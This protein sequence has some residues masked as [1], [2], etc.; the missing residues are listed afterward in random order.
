[1]DRRSFLRSLLMAGGAVATGAA[2]LPKSAEAAPFDLIKDIEAAAKPVPEAD[3]P[4]QGAQ[5]VWHRGRAH[6]RWQRPWRQPRRVCRTR[7]SR[8]GRVV[9]VCRW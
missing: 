2:L 9:R 6:G 8:W 5:E 3:L 4:A 1:M 7:V